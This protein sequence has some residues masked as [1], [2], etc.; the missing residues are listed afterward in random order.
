MFKLSDIEFQ[1]SPQT[2]L[3]SFLSGDQ[4]GN[5]AS[6]KSRENIFKLGLIFNKSLWSKSETLFD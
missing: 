1:V 3:P 5:D 2:P 4:N 6:A